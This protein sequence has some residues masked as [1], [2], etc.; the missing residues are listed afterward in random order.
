MSHYA[1]G[2]PC[3]FP[4]LYKETIVR[5]SHGGPISSGLSL[6]ISFW[7]CKFAEA[8]VLNINVFLSRPKQTPIFCWL[9]N[10]LYVFK[11]SLYSFGKDKY[12]LLD[13]LLY[14]KYNQVQNILCMPTVLLYML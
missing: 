8:Y 11:T 9:Y 5:D 2:V 1:G 6:P 10:M 7:F 13:Q 12:N 3:S 14:K 4:V